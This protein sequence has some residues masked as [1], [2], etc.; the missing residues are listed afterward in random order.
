MTVESTTTTA[1]SQ[2]QNGSQDPRVKWLAI[3]L[4]GL[5]PLQVIAPGW[6]AGEWLVAI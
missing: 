1:L 4:C 5:M 2:I 6:F 3:R